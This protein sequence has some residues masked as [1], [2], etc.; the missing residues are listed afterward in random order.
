MISTISGAFNT[1]SIAQK[2]EPVIGADNIQVFQNPGSNG[3][4]IMPERTGGISGNGISTVNLP[5]WANPNYNWPYN[6]SGW[7]VL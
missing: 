7:W 4:V 2:N 6:G 3:A 5:Y 1:E